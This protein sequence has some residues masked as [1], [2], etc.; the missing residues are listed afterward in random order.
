MD[1]HGGQGS[2]L[3]DVIEKFKNFYWL[4]TDGNGEPKYQKEIDRMILADQRSLTVDFM[5]LLLYDCSLASGVVDEPDKYIEHATT[6]LLQ[7]VS[8]HR[9][10]YLER[11][12]GRIH[13]RFKNV[14]NQVPIR[15]LGSIHIGKMVQIK[16]IV[17]KASAIKQRIYEYAYEC[18]NPNCGFTLK[19]RDVVALCPRCGRKMMVDPSKS[20]YEDFQ[21]IVVQE[22][23][24]SLPGSKIPRSI[25]VILSDDLVDKAKPGDKVIVTGIVRVRRE[26]S[27]YSIFIEANNIETLSKEPEEITI[28]G[29]DEELIREVS[30]DPNLI[31][32][33]V[34]S[35]AP[36]IYGFREIKEAI[37]YMMV[38]GVTRVAPDGTR[39]RGDINI[40]L[41]GDPGVGK[42]QLLKSVV[43]IAPKALYTSG[44]GSTAA[45]LT[46]TVLKDK[47][48]GEP[49]L[50]AGALV[51]ADGGICCIDEIDKMKNEDR[52]AMHEAMEQQTISIAKAGIVATLNARCSVLAAANPALGRYMPNRPITENIKLPPAI[53]SRFDLIFIIRDTPD[54]AEDERLASHILNI[55]AERFKAPFFNPQFIKKYIA[56]ARRL[57]PIMSEEAMQ[58]IMEYYLKLREAVSPDSPIAITPRQLESLIRLAEARAKLFLRDKV[59]AEDAEAAIRLMDYCLRT[60]AKDEM[61]RIDIDIIMSGKPKTKREKMLKIIEI[62]ERLEKELAG[63]PAHKDLIIEEAEKYGIDKAFTEDALEKLCIEGILCKPKSGYYK[64]IR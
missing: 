41:V 9:R 35:I 7:L 4:F 39:F 38:G 33:L 51:L 13:V 28:T 26:R 48:T 45:G 3:E 5:D 61:G 20:L 22:D 44:K 8:L 31:D 42:S 56:Y 36:S 58:K 49:F 50:E 63:Q 1:V 64:K 53:L 57:R 40:L 2:P 15:S 27:A 12:G 18:T 60:V 25:E 10:A 16:G 52:A 30:K 6:A 32:K 34:D 55:R 24:E 46:A 59:T 47:D 14:E 54:K 29:E 11:V 19:S 23:T 17:A 43:K 21:V 37:L 62:V